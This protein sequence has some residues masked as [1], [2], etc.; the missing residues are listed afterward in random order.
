LPAEATSPVRISL[1]YIVGVIEG[2]DG[3]AD[4]HHV[5]AWALTDG[6]HVFSAHMRVRS[7]TDPQAT[8]ESAHDMLKDRYGFFFSTIQVEVRCMNEADSKPLDITST[9]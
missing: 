3:L 5:H 8:L 6:R 4:V 1:V 7:E 9:I 2:L